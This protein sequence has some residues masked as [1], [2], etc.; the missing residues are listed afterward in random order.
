[1][2]VKELVS[3]S[4]ILQEENFQIEEK[5]TQTSQ[6]LEALNNEVQYTMKQCDQVE[7][8]LK[9]D[10]EEFKRACET[11]EFV[12]NKLETRVRARTHGNAASGLN[13]GGNDAGEGE[14]KTT[15]S[16][17]FSQ[18]YVVKVQEGNKQIELRATEARRGPQNVE[19]DKKYCNLI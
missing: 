2:K 18:S 3:K 1:M 4:K 12:R 15:K 13:A 19:T 16:N 8:E 11:M 5:I 10:T 7:Q 14:D 17:I 6:Y 9:A